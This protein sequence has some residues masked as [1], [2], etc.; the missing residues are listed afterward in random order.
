MMADDTTSGVSGKTAK[1]VY[2]EELRLQ[3]EM[4]EKAE[5]MSGIEK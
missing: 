5:K 4:A 3:S 1:N 2:T